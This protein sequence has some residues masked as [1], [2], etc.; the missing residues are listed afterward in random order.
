MDLLLEWKLTE[1]KSFVNE[2]P[3]VQTVV[4]PQTDGNNRFNITGNIRPAD[5]KWINT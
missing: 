3:I 4:W 1:Y 2:A 5:L